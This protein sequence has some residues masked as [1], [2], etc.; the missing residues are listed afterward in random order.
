MFGMSM[1]IHVQWYKTM[2]AAQRR[3]SSRK[4]GLQAFEDLDHTP[5]TRI[6]NLSIFKRVLP[7]IGSPS[8]LGDQVFRPFRR[9]S[10]TSDCI[11]QIGAF[12]IGKSS[13]ERVKRIHQSSGRRSRI[14]V[15]VERMQGVR[16]GDRPILGSWGRSQVLVVEASGQRV[17]R[18]RI[19]RSRSPIHDTFHLLVQ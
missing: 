9:V 19:Q 5:S 13:Y 6:R 2:R 1:Q 17:E 12:R 16:E 15:L 18:N 10:R 14:S 4:N 3:F 7:D 8:G 11:V